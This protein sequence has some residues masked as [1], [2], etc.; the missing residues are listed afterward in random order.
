MPGSRP[1]HVPTLKC[2]TSSRGSPSAASAAA[3]T[4]SGFERAFKALWRGGKEVARAET[5][6]VTVVDSVGAGDTFTA[7]LTV[8]LIE[9]KSPEDA[10]HF[11]VV[12]GAVACT[13]PGAQPSLPKRLDLDAWL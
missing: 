3:S 6:K 9:G 2:R 12:A 7:A 1:L 11:A 5:P 4:F 8:A 13:R 10:L